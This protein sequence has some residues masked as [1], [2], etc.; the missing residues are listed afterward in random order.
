[1]RE[2]ISH[3]SKAI[4]VPATMLLDWAREP[5]L[6]PIWSSWKS[7]Y[8]RHLRMFSHEEELALREFIL[9]NLINSGLFFTDSDFRLLAMQLYSETHPDDNP[10]GY[11]CS[12]GYIYDFKRRRRLPSRKNHYD[13]HPT[14]DPE[15]WPESAQRMELF[16]DTMDGD[17]IVNFDKIN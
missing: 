3:L 8:G 5:D 6:S 14:V 1:M 12:S 4:D 15:A 16:I 7:E 13:K 11:G 17:R 10:R 9:T 2:F